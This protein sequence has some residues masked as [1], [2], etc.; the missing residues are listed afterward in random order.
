MAASRPIR[1]GGS[2]LQV[3]TNR[4]GALA[5]LCVIGFLGYEC[6][7]FSSEVADAR[8]ENQALRAEQEL[9]RQQIKELK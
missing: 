9:H 7:A 8:A 1:R 2:A 4:I 6:I 5:A 3:N